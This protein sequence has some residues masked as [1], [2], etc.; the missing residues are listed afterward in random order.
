MDERKETADGSLL[1]NESDLM[2]PAAC[3]EALCNLPD[4]EVLNTMGDFFKVMSDPGRLRLL[5]VLQH[6]ELCPSDLAILTGSSR[7][8]VSHQLKTLKTA[9][10]VKTR[11]EGKTIYYSLD[12]DHIQNVLHVAFEHI[13]EK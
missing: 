8:A 11:K 4:P 13:S 1:P 9:K 12:D 5:L 10:L 3:S 7:S 2:D 6:C